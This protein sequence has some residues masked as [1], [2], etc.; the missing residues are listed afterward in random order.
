MADMWRN[1]YFFSFQSEEKLDLIGQDQAMV[2]HSHFS[3]TDDE[4][5]LK[6]S[7]SIAQSYYS[8][9]WPIIIICLATHCAGA[10][11]YLG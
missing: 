10:K 9:N 5:A 6:I 3:Q 2:K 1:S 8:L 11:R 4:V 7:L